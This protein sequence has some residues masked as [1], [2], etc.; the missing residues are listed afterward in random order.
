[1][2]ILLSVI[3]LIIIVV[4][5]S[6]KGKQLSPEEADR[7]MKILNG[8]LINLL[9]TGSEKPEFKVIQF[10][11]NQNIS[12]LPLH[13]AT[14]ST[15]PDSLNY[16]FD[17]NKGIYQ[18]DSALNQFI[19]TETDSIISLHFPEERSGVS[20]VDFY[21]NRYESQSYSSRP[22]LPV[23]AD[24][25]IEINKK[26]ITSLKH[27]A[28]I[29]NN[30]PENISTKIIG[31]DYEAGLELHRTQIKKKGTLKIDI[32]LKTKGFEIISG[33]A[34][35]QIEYSRQGY[36]F[37]TI[38]F[39]LKLMDHHVIGTINYGAIDPTSADYIHSFNSNSSIVLYEGN[40][41]VG[42]IVINKTENKDLLDYFI[43]FSNG[44]ETLL[45]YYIP[46]LKKLLNLKY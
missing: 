33:K 36:F 40:N 14:K 6:C 20:N 35:A 21:L 27:S 15:R 2:K 13:K 46:A 1:M 38:D 4:L 42:K 3:S 24:A 31:L 28:N 34:D 5:P 17:S 39:R 41:E 18:W 9:T 10:L 44:D 11:L 12:P 22:P 19:K 43:R 7:S 25:A 8:N 26:V 32:L 16:N 29:T 30:L 45:S 37:K 23:L